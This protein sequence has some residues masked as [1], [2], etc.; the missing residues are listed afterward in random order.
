MH[1]FPSLWSAYELVSNCIEKKK[2]ICLIWRKFPYTSNNPVAQVLLIT[3]V[4]VIAPCLSDRKSQLSGKDPDAGKD[5]RQEEKGTVEDE[6]VGWHH[7]LNGLSKLQELGEDMEAWRAAVRG[8]V[9]SQS[10]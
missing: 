8:A 7:W 9:E 1:L 4:A 10:K 3:P 2:K 5:G 6:M